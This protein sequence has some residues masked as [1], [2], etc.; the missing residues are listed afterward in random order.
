MPYPILMFEVNQGKTLST[1]S[2]KCQLFQESVNFFRK[3]SICQEKSLS[4]FSG[5]LH[6]SVN[7]NQE[8]TVC[9]RDAFRRF[10]V[11]V[12]FDAGKRSKFNSIFIYKYR[13]IFWVELVEF[14]SE[15]LKR[16]NACERA[17]RV[18]KNIFNFDGKKLGVYS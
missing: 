16:R 2:G 6:Y 12:V 4:T 15:T 1:L 9:P 11:S 3:E 5:K 17:P 7:Q 18:M 14:L 13:S 8:K 10:S